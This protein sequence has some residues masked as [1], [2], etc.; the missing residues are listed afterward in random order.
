MKEAVVVIRLQEIV[1]DVNGM[2]SATCERR[3]SD[4][5]AAVPGVAAARASRSE[6][7]AVVT[8]D[9]MQATAEKL[10]AAVKEAGYE[11][12]EMRFPE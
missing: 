8:A 10:R 6:G 4:A 2:S 7:Q 5:L 1:I 12:G 3:V 11:P 9:P